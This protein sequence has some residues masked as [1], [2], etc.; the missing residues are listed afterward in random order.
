MTEPTL[1]DTGRE[2]RSSTTPETLTV[3]SLDYFPEDIPSRREGSR[4]WLS[5]VLLAAVILHLIA[6]FYAALWA[7]DRL[8]GVLK[9]MSLTFGTNC[10]LLGT[11]LAFY[12]GTSGPSR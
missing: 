8:D 2:D 3:R 6:A 11:S 10:T 12:F 9:V 5:Y 7:P 1:G 4:R